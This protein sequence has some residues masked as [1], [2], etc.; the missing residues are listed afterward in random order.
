MTV[1]TIGVAT[2]GCVAHGRTAGRAVVRIGLFEAVV[3]G[4]DL[5]GGHRQPR[6]G[7]RRARIDRLAKQQRH[8]VARYVGQRAIEGD[9]GKSSVALLPGNESA[10][11]VLPRIGAAEAADVSAELV[12]LSGPAIRPDLSACASQ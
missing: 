1:L 11:V 7:R 4:G 5:L 6:Q 8:R 3:A 9:I 2:L 10:L 12:A